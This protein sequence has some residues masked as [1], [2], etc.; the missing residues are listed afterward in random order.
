ME[1]SGTGSWPEASMW[2]Q[3]RL[4]PLPPPR[5]T[6][7][8][9]ARAALSPWAEPSSEGDRGFWVLLQG[10]GRLVIQLF[11]HSCILASQMMPA[12]LHQQCWET[13]TTSAI[14]PSE[15]NMLHSCSDPFIPSFHGYTPTPA[16]SCFRIKSLWG[17]QRASQGTQE[18]SVVCPMVIWVS[19]KNEAGKKG[20]ECPPM[21][22]CILRLKASHLH[23]HMF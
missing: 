15:Q 6:T 19:E 21:W 2:K 16:S 10:S 9:V 13:M 11:S 12:F 7:R 18:T 5:A 8:P 17:R 20:R 1:P 4:T 3:L 22:T 23:L 14:V